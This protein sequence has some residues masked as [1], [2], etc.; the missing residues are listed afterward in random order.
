MNPEIPEDMHELYDAD[1]DRVDLVG[2]AA[3]GTKVLL[4]KAQQGLIPAETVRELV[5]GAEQSAVDGALDAIAKAGRALSAANE[6]ALRAAAEQIQAVLDKLPQSEP[7]PSLMKENAAM[8]DEIT[9]PSAEAVEAP[10]EKETAEGVLTAGEAREALG[11]P[12]EAAPAAEVVKAEEPEAEAVE[13]ADALVLVY[14]AT[15][16]PIGVVK[17]NSITPVQGPGTTDPDN[18]GDSVEDT[19]GDGDGPEPAEAPVEESAAEPNLTEADGSSHID[20]QDYGDGT[21][22][23]ADEASEEDEDSR[24]IPG[25][26]TVQSP[27]HKGAAEP[28]AETE[29]AA[30]LK[31]YLAPLAEQIAKAADLAAT[32]EV[33]KE[34]VEK[35]GAMPNNTAIPAFN[36]ATGANAGLAPRDNGT[37]DPLE[38]LKKA[39][40]EAQEANDAQAIQKANAA[41]LFESVK[42]R[43]TN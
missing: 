34:R 32:V 7:E 16:C 29:V 35:F 36:G 43:F 20:G 15:G 38:P 6:Q 5:K 22:A 14:D 21:P 17:P 31:E 40:A 41:L 9:A 37:N 10:V 27:V 39:L 8:A 24:V 19:D 1:I 33:L 28:A 13:K 18:D 3:N 4:A 26:D 42:A 12:A 11:F 25:T 2:A 23:D 30:V